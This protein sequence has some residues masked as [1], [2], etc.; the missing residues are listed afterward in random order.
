MIIVTTV[1]PPLFQATGRNP[2]QRQVY[3]VRTTFL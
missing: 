3:P 2:I 1:L